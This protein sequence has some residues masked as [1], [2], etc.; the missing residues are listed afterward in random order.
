MDSITQK[1]ILEFLKTAYDYNGTIHL[2]ALS[3]KEATAKGT[4]LPHRYWLR[5]AMTYRESDKV[6][7]YFD[8][9]DLAVDVGSEDIR[10]AA[11]DEWAD[12]PPIMEGSPNALALPWVSELAP[13][14]FVSQDALEAAR[15]SAVDSQQS[16]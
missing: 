9:T 2:L 7:P 1:R 14:F 4:D 5:I 15:E 10:F 12:G 8:G 11:E 6:C 16:H 3:A 13:P